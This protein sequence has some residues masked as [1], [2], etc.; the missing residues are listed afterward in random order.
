MTDNAETRQS[1]DAPKTYPQA[2]YALFL[3]VL[4]R[5]AISVFQYTYSSIPTL[6]SHYFGIT[7]SA[8]N[9]L[10]NVQC[11]VYVFMSFFT[12]YLFEKLGVKLSIVIA[13][14]LCA[15]GSAIRSLATI[16]NPPSFVWTMTGQTLGAIASPMALNIMTM[17]A[18]TWFTENLRATAGM[19]VA[20]N[21]GAILV[22]FAIPS[23][24]TYID[25][26]PLVLH[27]VSGF[28]GLTFLLLLSMP[29]KPPKPP[30][31]E[32]DVERPPYLKGLQMLMKNLNF[33]ILFFIHSFN[34]GLSIA[35][36]SLFAQIVG[37]HG[38]SDKHA[39][40]LNALAFFA[41]T[42]G[43]TTA[44]PVLDQTKQHK[45]LLKLVTPMVFITNVAFIFVIPR[46][47]FAFLLFV[48]TMNQFF[49]SFLVPVVI[50]LS[51]ETSYPVAES[52]SSSILW[53]GAQAFGFV[54]NLILDATR[55]PKGIPVNN[56][57][58]GLIFQ[59]VIAAIIMLLSF[60][61][62]GKMARLEASDW[63]AIPELPK[64]PKG[65]ETLWSLRAH[66]IAAVLDNDIKATKSS[67]RIDT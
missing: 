48:L 41:G 53:Q 47:S 57:I 24:A 14:V 34:V 66:P 30:T 25:K 3:L 38:Y 23:I 22:M 6:T 51:S 15:L 65:K 27:L 37:P 59:A 20:S 63:D 60:S 5:T 46:G 16:A 11:I 45:L 56:M 61:F 39:G 67:I 49:L 13:G 36:G 19:F 52:T 55:D 7:L 58:Y 17:F 64:S 40:L 4:L 12:G 21:Y 33:W 2:W 9:W 35:F 62:H 32:L 54:F 18:S 1:K 31:T 26:I 29:S 50:E 8:V 28:T 10:A 43:C 44:G 42:L